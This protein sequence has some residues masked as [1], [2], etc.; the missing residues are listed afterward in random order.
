M[1]L[2]H[3]RCGFSRSLSFFPFGTR[4]TNDDQSIRT[5]SFA[6]DSRFSCGV[7]VL[8]GKCSIF[9]DSDFSSSFWRSA[10][11]R[12]VTNKEE[13]SEHLQRMRRVFRCHRSTGVSEREKP[14][15]E[16]EMARESFSLYCD[17]KKQWPRKS[18]EGTRFH[19][20]KKKKEK[21]LVKTD[22]FT[23]EIYVAVV[24]FTQWKCV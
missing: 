12:G 11:D 8:R 3:I 4:P 9:N 13:V 14:G 6:K 22:Q 24:Q 1:A 19:L 2:S 15:G 21:L 5:S 17:G 23:L 16:R 18:W 10:G 20:W 7:R